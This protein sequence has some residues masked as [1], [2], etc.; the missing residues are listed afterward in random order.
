M[1]VSIIG[2]SPTWTAAD[3]DADEV[4]VHGNQLDRFK[5]HRITRIFEIHDI[6]IN[7]SPDYPQWLVNQNIPMIV[8]DKFPVKADHVKTFPQEC[9]VLKKLTSTPAYMMALAI[10]EGATEIGIYGVEMGVDNHEYFKQRSGMYSWIGYALGKGIKVT[11]P[12]ESSLFKDSYEEGRDWLKPKDAFS[13]EALLECAKLHK[14]KMQEY[15]VL[16]HTHNGS[17]QTY[18]RLAKVARAKEAGQN[19]NLQESMVIK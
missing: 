19:V 3:F 9:N 6:L 5:N 8:S 18:E 1:N 10:Y 2:G 16:I 14:E 17:I 4:W 15:E 11:I 13:E 7:Q 12:E